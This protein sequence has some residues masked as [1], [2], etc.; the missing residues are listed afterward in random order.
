MIIVTGA[1]GRLGRAVVQLLLERG[2]DVLG[3]DLVPCENSP[4][5]FVQADLCDLAAVQKF[6]RGADAVVHLGAIPGPRKPAPDAGHTEAQSTALIPADPFVIFEN[7]V[8]S[9]YNILLS[10]MEQKLRRVVFSSSAFAMG[11]AHDPR[12][13]LPLY[14]PLDEEHPLMPFEA[15]GLSKQ[16]GECIAGMV[17][18]SSSTSV[19][20]LRFTNVV[21]P[22]RHN[23]FPWP[24]P[25]PD[26]PLTLVMWAYADPRDVALAHVLALEAKLTGHEA[27]LIAQPITRFREPTRELIRQNF[28][29]RVEIRGELAGNASVISTAKAERLLSFKPSYRWDRP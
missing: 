20:S 6:M 1:A 9:T 18:R 13:F 17:A 25:T 29:D 15:Y 14:L 24:A 4:T 11:W 10:A 26:N 28:G 21:P 7:N 19:V 3:T 2:D 16:V 12:A 23:E 22:E 27:F 5:P 8:R